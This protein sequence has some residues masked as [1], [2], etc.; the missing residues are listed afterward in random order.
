MRNADCVFFSEEDV[1]DPEKTAQTYLAYTKMVVVTRGNRGASVF[2]PYGEYRAPAFAT[3]EVEPTGAGD[4]FA[5]AFLINY[6]ETH[7]FKKAAR[8]ANCVASFAVEKEGIYGIPQH[9]DVK[10]RLETVD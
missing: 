9:E 5:A 8:F 6:Y 4:V 2:S 10:H 7:D 3:V 1:A